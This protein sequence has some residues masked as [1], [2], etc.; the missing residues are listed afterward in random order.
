M[1]IVVF[2][3][4]ITTIALSLIMGKVSIFS[5]SVIG[6]LILLVTVK[7]TFCNEKLDKKEN[8]VIGICFCI[9]LLCCVLI[10]WGSID[11]YGNPY[12]EGEDKGDEFMFEDAARQLVENNNDSLLYVIKDSTYVRGLNNCKPYIWLMAKLMRWCDIFGGYH[13]LCYRIINVFLLTAA[14]LVFYKE[15]NK[16]RELKYLVYLMIFPNIIMISSFG[17]R[18]IILY[19]YISIAYK[20]TN[21]PWKQMIVSDYLFLFLSAFGILGTR[22]ES[23]MWWFVIVVVNLFYRNSK[24]INSRRKIIFILGLIT[25]FLIAFFSGP[26]RM[27]VDNYLKYTSYLMMDGGLSSIVLGM[28]LLPFGIVLRFVYG[29]LQPFPSYLIHFY[30]NLDSFFGIFRILVS[31]GTLWQFVNIPYLLRGIRLWHK[32]AFIYLGIFL[33]LILTTYGFRHFLYVYPFMFEEIILNK[34]GFS[35][36]RRRN[37][38]LLGLALIG[39]MGLA[40]YFLKI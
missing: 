13:V 24:E 32:D 34:E 17:F 11:R 26:Y 2:S 6:F 31:I 23:I 18:D 4:T 33:S 27:L 40:Y 35:L 29:L 37:I 19:Y 12:W 21:K 39:Y 1:G 10:Y 25:G 7:I 22:I 3:S 8:K 14:S 30:D 38:L 5:C 9:V 16:R 36:V 20:A 28:K 15:I